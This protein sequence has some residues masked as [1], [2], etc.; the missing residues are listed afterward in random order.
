MVGKR[1]G[2]HAKLADGLLIL[3]EMFELLGIQSAHLRHRSTSTQ[4]R[5]EDCVDS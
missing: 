3:H 4:V 2:K 5:L 1:V